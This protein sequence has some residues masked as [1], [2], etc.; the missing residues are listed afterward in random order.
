[1]DIQ[2][3]ELSP[4]G[5]AEYAGVPIGFEV[6]ERLTV[7][8]ADSRLLVEVDAVSDPYVKDYDAIPGNHPTD[9]PLRFDVSEWGILVAESGGAR[10]GGAVIARDGRGLEMLE[11]RTEVAALWDIRVAPALR[12]QGIGSELFRAAEDWALA[13][14]ARWFKIETQNIN[15]PACRFYERHGCTLEAA[16]SNAYP[17]FPDEVQLIWCKRLAPSVYAG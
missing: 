6:R 5:L 11:E 1:M 12:G 14:G 2:I 7:V 13:R 4:T 9:W 16:N 8:F 17:D 15:V 10:V 3:V